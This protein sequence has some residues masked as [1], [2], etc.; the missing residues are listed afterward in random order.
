MLNPAS[1]TSSIRSHRMHALMPL[2]SR[3]RS[4][5]G[6]RTDFASH[7]SRQWT[8]EPAEERAMQPAFYEPA[9]LERIRGVFEGETVADEIAKLQSPRVQHAPT[10]AYELRDVLLSRG[11]LFTRKMVHRLDTRPLPLFAR[12][13]R[14]R[15]RDAVLS[16][17]HYGIRF[18]GHWMT[19]DLTLTLAAR[20]LGDPVSV[21]LRPTAHQTQYLSLLDCA[22][23]VLDDVFFDRLV[24]LDDHGQNRY[25]QRRYATLR[26][27]AR[28]KVGAPRPS[29]GVMLLR[30]KLGVPR[31]LLNED[32]VAELLRRRGFDVLAPEQMS[33]EDLVR[34]CLDAPVVIGVEGSQLVHGIS[35]MAQDGVLIELQPPTRF[36]V[37]YR[38]RC[39]CEGIRYGCQVGH[40]AGAND[41][42][43]ID[44]AALERLLDRIAST[45]RSTA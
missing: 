6:L 43:T 45:P 2:I 11:H 8:L 7:S 28:A 9:D 3:T 23:P 27:R 38:G 5:L 41:D 25:K 15:L 26:Q 40:A 19:D 16:T 34:A 21:L 35:V 12:R 17:S 14:T 32:E 36:N 30:G 42:F 22:A 44:L 24:I 31:S 33:A 29:A 1:S 37:L 39:D 18:F 4:R 20:E 10:V 13:A